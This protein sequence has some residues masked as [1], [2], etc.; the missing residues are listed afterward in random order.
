MQMVRISPLAL[1]LVAGACGEDKGESTT[2]ATD[3]GGDGSST[4]I[5]PAAGTDSSGDATGGAISETTGDPDPGTT[6]DAT[7]CTSNRMELCFGCAHVRTLSPR[8]SLSSQPGG[9]ACRS[10]VNSR[11]ASC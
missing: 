3:T 11:A 5:A 10:A 6:G 2:D 1:A 8:L 4:G 7:L 9:G